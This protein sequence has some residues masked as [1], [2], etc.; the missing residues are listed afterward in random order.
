[1]KITRR[2]SKRRTLPTT[3]LDRE[4]ESVELDLENSGVTL[5]FQEILDPMD[6]AF[7]T[8]H[9]Y[10]VQLSRKDLLQVIDKL[11]LGSLFDSETDL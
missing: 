7:G 1:M 11:V 10:T 2:G 9:D 6:S 5:K 8:H 4:P 3:L